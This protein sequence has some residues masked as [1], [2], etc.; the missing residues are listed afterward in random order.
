M[1]FLE[2]LENFAFDLYYTMVLPKKFLNPMTEVVQKKFPNTPPIYDM[3]YQVI[4]IDEA[5]T[6][7]LMEI[8][9]QYKQGIKTSA[10]VNNFPDE[11]D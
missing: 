4:T 11:N 8:S 2:R 6:T 1:T 9:S 5:F 7:L 10:V 3:I